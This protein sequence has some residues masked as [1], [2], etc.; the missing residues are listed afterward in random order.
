MR[1]SAHSTP[2]SEDG[3]V[4]IL[5]ITLDHQRSATL[6]FPG[7]EGRRCE[8]YQ[9]TSP[10]VLGKSVLLNGTE[11]KVRGDGRLPEVSGIEHG[12]AGVRTVGLLPLA[13]TFAVF[14]PR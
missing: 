9:V 14:P 3:A 2:G 7:F 1:A 4:T 12:G 5:A 10:D 11:L 8:L 13:Y 6:S